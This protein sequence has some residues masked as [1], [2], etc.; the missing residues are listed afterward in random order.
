MVNHRLKEFLRR[1]LDSTISLK[2]VLKEYS[3]IINYNPKARL[4][5]LML[6]GAHSLEKG[7]GI[8]NT[9]IG[10]GRQ[11][12][13]NIINYLNDYC[14]KGY[15]C[16]CFP[17]VESYKMIETYI[18]FQKNAGFDISEIEV[19][20]DSF[21][22]RNQ[23]KINALTQSAGCGFKYYKSEYLKQSEDFCFEDFVSLRHSIRDFEEE[24]VSEEKIRKAIELANHAPSACNRQPVKVY[25]TNSLEVAHKVDDLITGTSGFKKNIHNFALIT[26]DRSYFAGREIYQWYV[27]GGIFLSFFILALH[28]LGIGSVV[29]QWFAFHTTEKELKQLMGIE[30][31]EA[32]VA[33]VGFGY[34]PD[35]V[36]CIEAQRKNWDEIVRFV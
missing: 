2:L 26:C 23:A 8:K 35:E 10:Y 36:K 15:D 6:V 13:T 7:M 16:D 4:E 21:K 28:S 20:F 1:M 22:Q 17:F 31:S 9:R 30:N 12:A 3:R 19:L 24:I 25:C 33:V 18:D 5:S 29:M 27:N 14:I 11:K 34:Y 32:I